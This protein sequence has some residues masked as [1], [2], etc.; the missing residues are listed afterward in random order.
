[1]S[2]RVVDWALALLVGALAT[3]G[4]LTLFAGARHDAWV[5]DLHDALSAA[6]AVALVLKLRRV[7]PRVM[8]TARWD[9][10]TIAGVL[11]SLSAV[12]ALVS[13]LFWSTGVT[14][15]PAGFS[16]L[17]WHEA[18]GA[19]LLVVIAVHMLLRAK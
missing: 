16:L 5:F 2:A 3:T 9:R 11:G 8:V 17:A 15:D 13:G 7:W 18:L 10:R 6:I 12:A 4:A 19:V 1:M 14:P